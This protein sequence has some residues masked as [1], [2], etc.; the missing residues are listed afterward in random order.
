MFRS[1]TQ[2]TRPQ[3]GALT[4]S[5][6]ARDT[7]ALLCGLD[8]QGDCF[9]LSRETAPPCEQGTRLKHC[10]IHRDQDNLPLNRSLDQ[11]TLSVAE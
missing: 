6:S 4:P 1:I 5:P 3:A 9:N 10:R 8:C 2:T 11:R 7:L